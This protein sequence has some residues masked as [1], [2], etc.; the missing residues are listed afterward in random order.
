MRTPRTLQHA[1]LTLRRTFIALLTL[2]FAS[3][4]ATSNTPSASAQRRATSNTASAKTTTAP[5]FL[6]GNFDDD[7]GSHFTVSSTDF[8]Q[9]P[10]GRFRI[11]QWNVAEQY[12]IAQNDSVNRSDPGK[13]TRIDWLPLTG[14][15]PYTWA[16]CFSAYNATTRAAA[17]AASSANRASPKTGC[18]GF[19]FTRMKRTG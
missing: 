11:V 4:C 3:A 16:F 19:P 14:L 10:S 15:E 8:L 1:D 9:L 18:A 17:E 7:Y 5:A 2:S 6:L 13:W 12:F